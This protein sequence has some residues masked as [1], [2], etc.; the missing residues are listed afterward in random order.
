MREII[1]MWW[2]KQN[3]CVKIVDELINFF[4]QKSIEIIQNALLKMG[5]RG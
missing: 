2:M 4:I 3:K 5:L 1:L